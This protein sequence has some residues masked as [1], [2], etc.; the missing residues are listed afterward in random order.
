MY[1]RKYQKGER[2]TSMEQFAQW[3]GQEQHVYV[4]GKFNHF[5]WVTNMQYRVIA[6]LVN[7]GHVHKAVKIIKEEI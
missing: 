3:V 5:G 2:I 6:N 1:K 4:R 7:G